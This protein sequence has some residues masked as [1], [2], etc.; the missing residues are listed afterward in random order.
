MTVTAIKDHGYCGRRVRA[1]QDYE[2]RTNADFTVLQRAGLI[3]LKKKPANAR[4]L[5]TDN[6]PLVKNKVITREEQPEQQPEQQPEEQTEEQIERQDAGQE[7]VDEQT[8]KP[9]K[10]RRQYKRHDMVPED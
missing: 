7:Q 1:G 2:V 8:G 4:I 10:Q 6:V 3:K 9:R 5:T